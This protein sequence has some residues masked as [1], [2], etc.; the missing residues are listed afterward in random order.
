MSVE[1]DPQT[2]ELSVG[3]NG[4]IGAAT[5]LNDFLS[6]AAGRSA[7]KIIENGAYRSFKIRCVATLETFHLLLSFKNQSIQTVTVARSKPEEG[8]SWEI[9]SEE[10]E[11]KRKRIHNAWLK[12]R[13]GE[14]P[15]KFRWGSVT[16]DCD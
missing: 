10:A 15:Y 3:A 11:Q 7:E 14:P 4:R 12:E 16:S 6:S 1:I 2:G 8:S 13:L 5:T 9:W